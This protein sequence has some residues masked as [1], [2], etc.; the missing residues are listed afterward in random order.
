MTSRVYFLESISNQDWLPWLGIARTAWYKKYRDWSCCKIIGWLLKD[1]IIKLW[2]GHEGWYNSTTAL[3][4][5]LD[6]IR[7][8]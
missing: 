6:Y 7:L 1:S 4:N 5:N 2:N 8:R 3:L